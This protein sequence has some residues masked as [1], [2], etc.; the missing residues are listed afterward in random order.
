MLALSSAIAEAQPNKV[1]SAYNYHRYYENDKK[2]EDLTNAQLAIDMAIAHE[3]TMSDEKTWFYR[4]K[5]YHSIF[6][7]KDE[8]FKEQKANALNEAFTSYKKSLELDAKKEYSSE[9]MQRLT[10]VQVQ[11]I[12]LGVGQ[13]EAKTFD[14]AVT[15]FENAVSLAAIFQKIDTLALYNA[16][17]SAERALQY[18]KAVEYYTKLIG[19][20]YGEAKIY[21]FLANIYKL[22]KNEVKAQETIKEGRAAYPNDKNLTIEELNYYLAQGKF[23]E[24]VANLNLAIAGDPNNQLLYFSL[25]T[26]YDN[27]ANPPKEKPQVTEAEYIEYSQKAEEAYKKALML[28]PD[29]FDA[30]YNLGALYF[31]Q[32]VK[33]N[34]MANTIKDNAKYAKEIKVADDKFTLSLPYLEKA[35]E[36]GTDDKKTYTDLLNTL[37]QLYART[38]QTDKYNKVKAKLIN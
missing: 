13:F 4:G 33:I 32:G 23:K 15:S 28:K 1:V 6:E 37:K 36:I 38:N 18:D 17:L 24:A 34:E 30:L 12:N 8:K 20:K 22:Q 31:N 16:A 26:I 25:G 21:S 2:A 10:V 3:K 27:L 11:Y 19:Y 29:Y 35:E 7:S 14:K 9:I 5:I